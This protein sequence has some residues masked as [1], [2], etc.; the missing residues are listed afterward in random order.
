MIDPRTGYETD[1]C[2]MC[3]HSMYPCA[4]GD[5]EGCPEFEP[6]GP[7]AMDIMLMLAIDN[8]NMRKIMEIMAHRIIFE[9]DTDPR[10][11][12]HERFSAEDIIQ[13]PE[14]YK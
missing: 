2:A 9:H 11:R 4:D 6:A 3:A 7:D 10:T 8:D 1:A 12:T 5:V 14:A 13:N